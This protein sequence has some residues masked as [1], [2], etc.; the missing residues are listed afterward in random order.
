MKAAFNPIFCQ[1]ILEL[2]G[3]IQLWLLESSNLRLIPWQRENNYSDRS[4]ALTK[5]P[6]CVDDTGCREAIPQGSA[7]RCAGEDP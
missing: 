4:Y 3:I 7:L 1:Y 6:N 2:Q 5:K